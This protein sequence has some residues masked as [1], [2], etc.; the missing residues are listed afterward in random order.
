MIADGKCTGVYKLATNDSQVFCELFSR[1]PPS[2]HKRFFFPLFSRLITASRIGELWA[3]LNKCVSV[4]LLIAF[5]PDTTKHLF[6]ERALFGM[7]GTFAAGY[8]LAY[9]EIWSNRRLLQSS[10]NQDGVRR[11]ATA[12]VCM[13]SAKPLRSTPIMGGSGIMGS[14]ITP[15]S[16]TPVRLNDTITTY[17]HSP[18]CPSQRLK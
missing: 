16:L 5:S 11:Q 1:L 13:S 17:L 2:L 9:Q 7:I 14:G 4:R 12:A 10:Q 15:Q 6:S 18:F 8:Q 3:P